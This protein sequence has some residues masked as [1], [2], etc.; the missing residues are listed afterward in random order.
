[1]R[2]LKLAVYRLRQLVV[3]FRL[4]YR[5]YRASELGR[6]WSVVG[7]VRAAYIDYR[8]LDYLYEVDELDDE[9]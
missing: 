8:G 3:S 9:D 4:W 1:M 7:A 6:V 5:F 2:R